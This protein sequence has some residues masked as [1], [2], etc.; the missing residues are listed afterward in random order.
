M[1]Y[2][3]YFN[4][5]AVLFRRIGLWPWNKIGKTHQLLLHWILEFCKKTSLMD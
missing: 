3:Q 1:E 2:Q 5:K 4:M